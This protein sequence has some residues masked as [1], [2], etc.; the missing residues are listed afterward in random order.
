VTIKGKIE[1]VMKSN[2]ASWTASE[3]TWYLKSN[4]NQAPSLLAGGTGPGLKA[5]NS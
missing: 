4:G 3:K 2:F 1:V 5:G